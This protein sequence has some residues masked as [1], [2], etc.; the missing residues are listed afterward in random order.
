[1]SAMDWTAI[2]ALCA[3][4]SVFSAFLG[5]LAHRAYAAG[6]RDKG[7]TAQIEAAEAKVGAVQALAAAALAKLDMLLDRLHKHELDDAAALGELRATVTATGRAQVDAENRI[8][9]AIEDFGHE[10]QA[11]GQRIDRVLEVGISAAKS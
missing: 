3:A 1:M 7:V 6:T 11:M 9:K 10:M 4:I 8:A 5:G 2:T